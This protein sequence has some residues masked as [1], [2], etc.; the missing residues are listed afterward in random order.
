MEKKKFLDDVDLDNSVVNVFGKAGNF[1]YKGTDAFEWIMYNP[2]TPDHVTVEGVEG[3]FSI[4]EYAI[5][6]DKQLK[7]KDEGYEDLF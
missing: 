7:E 2:L 6:L 4:D 1:L 5:A 3:K